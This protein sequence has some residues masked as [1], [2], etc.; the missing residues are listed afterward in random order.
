[1]HVGLHVNSTNSSA[2]FPPFSA[3]IIGTYPG[4]N[5]LFDEQK[6]L[7]HIAFVSALHKHAN[8]LIHIYIQKWLLA[9]NCLLHLHKYYRI[10]TTPVQF[11]SDAA[12]AVSNPCR[13]GSV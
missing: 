5:N 8:N 13:C 7:K 9:R 1:M 3:M 4:F 6:V 10:N 2:P 11:S 12:V